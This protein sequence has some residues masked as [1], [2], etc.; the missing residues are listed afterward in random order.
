MHP[1]TFYAFE[2][3]RDRQREAERSRLA[4][5]LRASRPSRPSRFRRPTAVALAKM[6]RGTAA[7]VDR[8]DCGVADDL[9]HS[10][11]ASE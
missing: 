6:T 8:L 9:R 5:D 4:A 7:A 11:A 10:L 3:A 2:V 1:W